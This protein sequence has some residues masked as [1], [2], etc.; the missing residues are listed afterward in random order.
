[1]RIWGL[2]DEWTLGHEGDITWIRAG[3]LG[4]EAWATFAADYQL[5]PLAVEDVRN[6]RQRPKLEV[7]GEETIFILRLPDN[8]Q[9]GVFRGEN[10]VVSASNKLLP[11]LNAIEE[12]LTTIRSV[13]ALFHEILDRLFDA[14]FPY[15][16][17]FEQRVEEV[18]DRCL[19]RASQDDL[20]EIH[21]LKKASL[22]ARKQLLPM[23]DAAVALARLPWPPEAAPYFADLA[24]HAV[25][26]VE[27]NEHVREVAKV[28]QDSWNATLANGQN[29]V[30]KRLTVVAGLL[31]VPSLLAGLGGMNFEGF[32]AWDYWTVTLSIVGFAVIGF[33]IAFR[34]RWI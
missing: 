21:D 9:V 32:P 23:R 6:P 24:D 16:D 30:M 8:T 18:E 3:G 2:K 26:L 1:M 14:W 29:A 27:R 22:Q 10:F 20:L 31:L 25:R 17:E 19:L 7:I 5:H 12:K 33:A 4:D 28:A 13:D 11:Q 15:L 34:K